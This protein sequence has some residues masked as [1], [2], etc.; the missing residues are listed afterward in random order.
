MIK[1]IIG[2]IILISLFIS[3]SDSLTLTSPI[4]DLSIST[5]GFGSS[6]V[7][8]G[9]KPSANIPDNGPSDHSG[10]ITAAEWNDLDSWTFWTDLINGSDYSDKP[11]YWEF[12]N[13]HRVA[14]NLTHN[15]QAVVDADV[16]L[17]KDNNEIW[18]AKSDNRGNAE[19]WINMFES[20]D[21]NDLSD[22]HVTVNGVR[23]DQDLRLYQDGIN[24]ISLNTAS[25]HSNKVELCFIV[26]ATGS[27]GDELEFLKDDLEDVI[28]VVLADNSSLVI[29]T[30]SVFYRDV[31]DEYVTRVSNFSDDFMETI[32]FIRDQRAD[33]GGDTPEAVHSALDKA[34][35]KL[36]WSQH[37]RTRIAF[38]LLDAPPHH[39]P[40]VVNDLQKSIELAAKKGIKIIPITASGIDKET[41]FLMRFFSIATNGTYVFITDD[42]GIGNDHLEASVGDYEVQFLNDLMVRLI[43]KYTQ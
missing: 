4:S 39:E 37:A 36:Q 27:M 20:S 31:E 34:I 38:L 19:V 26:D 3:C 43:Q 22:Y 16:A 15:G 8:S 10:L 2:S 21:I 1:Q 5:D 30:A 23:I 29:H 25:S 35:D 41:E 17:M 33:G 18:K 13:H 12:Y 32:D 6:T 14:I 28:N 9:E 40:Q 42:S 7:G 24:D 11:D